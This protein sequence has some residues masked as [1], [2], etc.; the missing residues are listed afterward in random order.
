MSANKA[1]N[2]SLSFFS[3]TAIFS[4]SSFPISMESCYLLLSRPPSRSLFSF[5]LEF[6]P[7]APADRVTLAAGIKR[8]EF[9]S[10][11]RVP[12]VGLVRLIRPGKSN[13]YFQASRKT[14]FHSFPFCF[15]FT[16][17][18]DVFRFTGNETH[19]DYFRLMLRDGSYLLVGGR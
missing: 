3:S 7:D 1:F 19:T 11:S 10:L 16:G 8:R 5:L 9:R 4:S 2:H 17:A 12:R 13:F 18:E 14:V 15:L 6:L